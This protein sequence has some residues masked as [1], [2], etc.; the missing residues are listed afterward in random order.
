MLVRRDSRNRSRPGH[1][2]YPEQE[3]KIP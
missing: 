3:L 2:I 1:W